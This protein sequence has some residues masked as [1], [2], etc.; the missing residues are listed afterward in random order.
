MGR[1]F[2]RG[3]GASATAAASEGLP[4]WVY[5]CDS[6]DVVDR[7]T[8]REEEW[9][10]LGCASRT[11]YGC[12]EH[13][14]RMLEGLTLLARVG[15]PSPV[16]AS[17]RIL[18][19]DDALKFISESGRSSA[20]A[21]ADDNFIVFLMELGPFEVGDRFFFLVYDVLAK[22]PAMIP[23]PPRHSVRYRAKRTVLV[24]GGGGG[25]Y[26]LVL[27]AN[28]MRMEPMTDRVPVYDETLCVWSPAAPPPA[29]P[30]CSHIAPWRRKGR[31]L[32]AGHVREPDFFYDD[33]HD[34]VDFDFIDLPPGHI[35]GNLEMEIPT[36]F[37]NMCDVG[38][39]VKYVS[40]DHV[41][42]DVG[43]RMVAVWSLDLDQ[44]LWTRDRAFSVRSLSELES[45]KK[46]GMPGTKPQCP[47]LLP[48]D[49]LVFLVPT[50]VSFD[51]YIC[52]LDM[53]SKTILWSGRLSGLY[54]VELTIV[55]SSLFRATESLCP[56]KRKAEEEGEDWSQGTTILS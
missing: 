56:L 23:A 2:E 12:G 5:L 52:S 8:A 16:V 6:L 32:P 3:A 28:L 53:R 54:S 48:D 15:H 43:G 45:F 29:A 26:E 7:R 10:A 4:P 30:A 46:A 47:F 25:D 44:K 41:G 31:L 13:G 40:V 33:C 11:A 37:R 20:A 17:L 51:D 35:V 18:L 49:I 27:V 21:H 38:D 42:D 9:A 1:L 36:L 50:K 19:D 24:P 39:S 34:L 55:L 14:Q 22:T